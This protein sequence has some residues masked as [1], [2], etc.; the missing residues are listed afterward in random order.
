MQM[1]SGR[2]W[3]LVLLLCLSVPAFAGEET[4]PLELSDAVGLALQG[5][6]ALAAYSYDVRAAEARQIQA[7]LRPNPE[8]SVEVEDLPIGSESQSRTTSWTVGSSGAAFSRERESSESEPEVTISL[9]HVIELGGKRARR[10]DLAARDHHVAEW[11]YEIARANVLRDVA[12]AYVNVLAAQER[13]T[14]NNVLVDLSERVLDSVKAR[15]EAGRV[16]PLEESKAQTALS[17]ARVQAERSRRRLEAARTR[18]ASQWGATETTFDTVAGSLEQVNALPDWEA[19]TMAV[20]QSPD[21][22]R[23]QAELDKRGAAVRL[24][25]ANAVPD[26]TVSAGFRTTRA[27]DSDATGVGIGSDGWSYSRS[28]NRSSDDWNNSVVLGVSVPLPLFNRNQGS[29]RE[30][31]Q[32]AAKASEERRAA[33]VGLNAA[34]HEAYETLAGAYAAI[35]ALRDGM[36]PLATQTFESFSEA[37]QQGKSGSLDVFDAQRT[38]FELKHQYLDAL[39]E[40]HLATADVERL[41]GIALSTAPSAT[42]K[43]E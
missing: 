28:Q 20:E 6:P 37:Y 25:K 5:N 13:L 24:E 17:S 9:S 8:L 35:L 42:E 43:K 4:G 39:T 18:L 19:L 12:Q 7:G 3:S 11:D 15:V 31:E 26:L 38:L 36:L 41:T 1:P 27:A 16:S 14:L 40:Y 30:A 33:T 34:L 10:L 23:W 2:S 22:K 32:L 21:L 29:I